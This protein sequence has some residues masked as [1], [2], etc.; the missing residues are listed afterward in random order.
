MFEFKLG[1]AA[2]ADLIPDDV[3]DP[4]EA[5]RYAANGDSQQLT[6]GGLMV[7]R[8]ADNWTAF[9]DGHRTWVN[10][11]YGLQERLNTERFDWE[12]EPVVIKSPPRRFAVWMGTAIPWK[13]RSM[14]DVA[15]AV[16]ALCPPGEWA[17]EVLIKAGEGGSWQ[18]TWDK[19]PLAVSGACMLGILCKEGEAQGLTVTPY[20]VIRGKPAWVPS[21]I[22]QIVQAAE[23]A[24]R[25]VL[26]LE[27]GA[28]YWNG[29]TDAEAVAA[30]YL[31]P[32]RQLLAE[33]A[34]GAVIELAAIPRQWVIDSLGG[35]DDDP[36]TVS[37]LEAW[38][39]HVDAMSWE[40]YG[41][42]AR[43]LRPDLAMAR[44]ERWQADT[45][46]AGDP[47]FRIP[48]IQRSMIAG[49][50][51]TPECAGGV[52]IWHLDGNL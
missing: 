42:A 35:D 52:E 30:G 41:D 38:M 44:V 36:G 4:L 13:Y 19:H 47:A 25:V 9:T 34:P 24:G 16:Q 39:E 48:I 11:P 49:W 6:T 26:N 15:A 12:A 14:A 31:R 22:E 5:E 1:F 50:V 33:R 23:V 27:P 8:K 43:D 18:S 32:L 10:G 17:P 46:R 20:F 40:T 45:P 37:A 3:G 7:W 2:L 28:M 51:G 29:P 21:E